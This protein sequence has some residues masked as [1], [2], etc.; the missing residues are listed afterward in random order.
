[1]QDL[2]QRAEL[3][4]GDLEALA[5]AGALAPLS[6]NRHVAF[7]EVAGSER[8]LPLAPSSLAGGDE[9]RPLLEAPTEWQGIEADYTSLGLT[10]GRHPLELLRER[11]RA[12]RLA[13]AAEL[14]ALPHG[15][16]VRTAGIV[17]LRQHPA[18]AKGVTFVTIEDETGHVN[19]VV[20]ERIGEAQRR[21][22]VESRLLEVH[23][24]L[25]RQ[26][27][28]LHLV[29]SRLIDRSELLGPMVTRSRD[30]H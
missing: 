27:E 8:P 21:P 5:A 4:R 22:L 25:Q 1:V 20:W 18:N 6:G 29:V 28:V 23:G 9:G 24:R 12:E 10:L 26:G 11:L 13:T 16:R 17:L 3:D 7:W 14:A 19:L 15:K 2:A 30:F